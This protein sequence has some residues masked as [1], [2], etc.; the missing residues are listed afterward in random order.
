MNKNIKQFVD[1]ETDI[2]YEKRIKSCT[3]LLFMIGIPTSL[4]GTNR[5]LSSIIILPIIMMFFI[6]SIYLS[7]NTIA[8]RK[9]V[10]LFMGSSNLF[11]T[12]VL[13]IAIFKLLSTV[14]TLSIIF[15]LIAYVLLGVF[16][17]LNMLISMKVIEKGTYLK[18]HNHI[19]FTYILPYS[20]LGFCIAKLFASRLNQNSIIIVMCFLL[21]LLAMIFTMGSVHIL[22]FIFIKHIEKN[23]G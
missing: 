7:R 18:H 23:T 6:W 5:I 4:F 20:I 8:K 14:Y 16:I 13:F 9:W 12:M 11:I 21:L 17:A 10:Y 19:S 22:K 1:Y 3:M 2:S 15:V